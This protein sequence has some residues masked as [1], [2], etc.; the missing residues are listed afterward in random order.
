MRDAIK[1]RHLALEAQPGSGWHK[2]D[3]G[4]PFMNDLMPLSERPVAFLMDEEVI[5]GGDCAAVVLA[6][7]KRFVENRAASPHRFL[8]DQQRRAEAA[9]ERQGMSADGILAV[10]RHRWNDFNWAV[11]QEGVLCCMTSPEG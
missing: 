1:A 2:K 5:F 6:A 11:Q 10:P 3:P 9:A 7:A 4:S 8:D